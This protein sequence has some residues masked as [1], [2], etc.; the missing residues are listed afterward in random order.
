[1]FGPTPR[2]GLAE[3]AEPSAREEAHRAPARRDF[4]VRRLYVARSYPR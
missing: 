1:M 3:F 2:D 4:L